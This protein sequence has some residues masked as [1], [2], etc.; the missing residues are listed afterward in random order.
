V[1][2]ALALPARP[3]VYFGIAAFQGRTIDLDG[4]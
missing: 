3:G 2:C 4:E 1:P